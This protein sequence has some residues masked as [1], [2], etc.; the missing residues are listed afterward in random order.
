MANTNKSLRVNANV[1]RDS[2]VNVA[3]NQ[4]YDTFEILSLKLRSEDVYRL[5][6][7]NYGVIV[8]RVVANGNFGVPN[9]KISVFISSDFE[10]DSEILNTLYP[11]ESTASKKDDIRYN[12]LP[13]NKV[14]DCH[15]VVGTFPNKTYLLDN[16]SLIEVFDKYYV[17]T[18]RTNNA[19]DYIIMGVPTGQHTIHMD[20][21][22]SDCGILSQKP[23]D[24][25]YKGYTIEQFEN[26]NQF[27]TDKNLDSLSQIISQ[28]QV[29]NVIPFWGNADNGET[30]GITRADIEISFKFEPTCV[31]IGSLVADNSSNGISKKCVPT[32]Q[33]GAMDELTTGEGTIEMIRKTPGDNIES[34]Q[35]KG[36]ELIDGNGI[37][38][39][40]IPMNLDY[41]MTDEYGN[42]VPTD[43]P[44]KGVPTRARVRFRISMEDNEANVDNYFRAKVLV[45][46]NPLN[47]PTGGHEDYDY[48][49][50]TNTREESFRD[51]FWN[52]VYTVKSYIPRFQKPK[53]NIRTERFSGIK[54][55]N[56][57]GQNN[58][59]PYNN[60]RI[61]LP[62]EF[63][64]LCL[65]V[66]I[67]INVVTFMNRVIYKIVRLLTTISPFGGWDLKIVQSINYI[68]LS[69]GFCEE[70]ENWY[71]AP[72]AN[73]EKEF[74]KNGVPN[75]ADIKI[76]GGND[77]VYLLEECYR[78]LTGS[79]EDYSNSQVQGY[80]TEDG[81]VYI[82]RNQATGGVG[83]TVI[84]NYG[85]EDEYVV[86][87]ETSV[88][89][90]NRDDNDAM[91]LTVNTDYL[92]SCLEMALAQKYK[93]INFD[94]YNDWINGVIYMPR[95]MRVV[96]KKRSFL[97]G[98]IK[99]KPKV[100]GCMDDTRIFNKTRYYLQQCALTY[101]KDE[102][103]VYNNTYNTPNG[104]KETKPRRTP[105]Q[106]CHKKPGK[107]Y[108]PIFGGNK[109]TPTGNGGIVHENET[110]LKEHV[111]YFKP[112]EWGQN[113]RKVLLFANDLVLLGSLNDCSMYGIPQAFRYLKSSTYIMPTNLALTNMEEDGYLYATPDGTIC[114]EKS[115]GS[116]N[117]YENKGLT[118]VDTT[119]EAE[120]KY[121]STTENDQL[122]F[123]N[124]PEGSDIVDIYDDT[125]PL[126]EAAGIAWN[127]TGPGQGEKSTNVNTSLYMPGGHFLGISCFN[128]ETNIKSCINLQRVCEMGSNISQRREEIRE[129]KKVD[130]NGEEYS[131]KYRYFVPTGLISTDDI[132][133]EDFRTMF[134]TMNSKR[135][136]CEDN[137]VDE[138]TGYLFYRFNY[139]RNTGF[140]G[141]LK[142]K[143]EGDKFGAW[144]KKL[145]ITDEY[146][147]VGINVAK[148]VNYD[149]EETGETYTRTWEIANYD[150]FAFRF[151]L[152]D[153]DETEQLKH[154][155]LWVGSDGGTSTSTTTDDRPGRGD[156]G[157]SSNTGSGSSGT[158]S[159]S[160]SGGGRRGLTKGGE[161]GDSNEGN[162][163]NDANG[164]NETG[165]SNDENG[166]EEGSTAG[167]SSGNGSNSGGGTG[168]GGNRRSGAGGNRTSSGMY[169]SNNRN[170]GG[171]TV[172]LPQY[173]N[174]FYFY[175]GLQDGAT[176]LDEFNKQFFSVCETDSIIT[177]KLTLGVKTEFDECEM[178]TTAYI[179]GKDAEEPL[180]ISYTYI[181]EDG[182][183]SGETFE[184]VE[185]KNGYYSLELPD[186]PIGEYTFIA[187]DGT[188]AEE[189]RII[190]LGGNNDV[191]GLVDTQAFIFQVPSDAT[192]QNVS[193]SA[194]TMDC[195][196][197]SVAGLMFNGN[198]ISGVPMVT[199][200]EKDNDG[201][202]VAYY[203][204]ANGTQPENIGTMLNGI[205]T[206]TSIY[207]RIETDED[208]G[209]DGTILVFVWKPDTKYD[210]YVWNNNCDDSKYYFYGT[211]IVGGQEKVNLYLGDND[212][213]ISYDDYLKTL[214][215][216]DEW[217]NDIASDEEGD[218]LLDGI[219]N[220]YLRYY[221]IK[222]TSSGTPFTNNIIGAKDNG[223]IL[224]TRLF[225]QPER[226]DDELEEYRLVNG[227]CY[228]DDK[229]LKGAVS[230]MTYIP[231]WPNPPYTRKLFGE[232]VVNGQNIGSIPLISIRV[233]DIE[234]GTTI[235]MEN[236]VR[237]YHFDLSQDVFPDEELADYLVTGTSLSYAYFIGKT[238]D[239]K[240]YY[241]TVEV[242]NSGRVFKYEG[243][244]LS[245]KTITLYPVFYYPVMDRAFDAKLSDVDWVNPTIVLNGDNNAESSEFNVKYEDEEFAFTIDAVNGI[246]Y[247]NKYGACT[248][249]PYTFDDLVTRED[250]TTDLDLP[251]VTVKYGRIGY[252]KP[253]S[254]TTNCVF[255]LTEGAPSDLP[256]QPKVLK[257]GDSF[258]TDLATYIS[259]RPE[260]DKIVFY[261]DI[262]DEVN[263]YYLVKS[264]IECPIESGATVTYPFDTGSADTVLYLGRFGANSDDLL[265]VFKE[266]NTYV[267]YPG[268]YVIISNQVGTN[269][270]KFDYK[271]NSTTAQKVVKE[272]QSNSTDML[273]GT[274]V[275]DFG[276]TLE[277]TYLLKQSY[278]NED[279]I[280]DMTPYL[281]EILNNIGGDVQRITSFGDELDMNLEEGDYVICLV[282]TEKI[283]FVRVYPK[284]VNLETYDNN[285]SEPY[286]IIIP[287]GTTGIYN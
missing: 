105:K 3:L 181:T 188:G 99:I 25:V 33:M 84:H 250:G 85:D 186:L 190:E 127:Y 279:G 232:M 145:T 74:D 257:V 152:S 226:Y 150:Y 270:F 16:D 158:G 87:D 165:D 143:I 124:S 149:E 22:L 72:G 269:S 284:L 18:T 140:G 161:S 212:F 177:K 282:R 43:D 243:S 14:S 7:A 142:E 247:K 17:Y 242:T 75:M 210:V 253:Y 196:Y 106:K 201:N 115:N 198:E 231:T 57:H 229:R 272:F 154:F 191:D 89:Y 131:I 267:Q 215:P 192:P 240:L 164:G 2:F 61:K 261:N 83:Y 263:E 26:P 128:S 166:G 20:L 194:Q 119:F 90:Q 134:A 21:D 146:S 39:Y 77:N 280:P 54:H 219:D 125:I 234:S 81:D 169:Q 129:I 53:N 5:H 224:D 82:P 254:A 103:G 109:K 237:Y 244:R 156:S 252:L 172:G 223:Y 42:M 101:S 97:W 274:E 38:C 159:G 98:L 79:T 12:L 148:D 286:L 276:I 162:G 19:G 260:N 116:S 227:I 213:K 222:R 29:V 112:C 123:G 66:K 185:V 176:A 217:W 187:V 132:N 230:D 251:E 11:Y 113:N 108:Y 36:T 204:N 63:S 209:E 86:N 32:N 76:N 41:M 277:K 193:K 45:P 262:N 205:S 207:D 285:A 13:D 68:V 58:P 228:E 268:Q 52:N 69:N 78:N 278:F 256:F 9:A 55:C 199:I 258:T 174:S 104:C 163:G 182:E 88:D 197:I 94:F 50:G 195:G 171:R 144:N 56:I 31:F 40:Q 167:G 130:E 59:M 249:G 6:S 23:R 138:K 248:F 218:E 208:T 157:G 259:Y 233:A 47:L 264:T 4:T 155:L 44:T 65:I 27:K 236:G 178:T 265:N 95:W 92:L 221:L 202:A 34:Y 147:N 110:M 255:G 151:G 107:K 283:N 225:G 200:V 120:K 139:L 184:N 245:A 271:V 203:S 180:T 102:N 71:F 183:T 8:G 235:G 30:I 266:P 170:G 100:K 239:G 114:S 141:E 173:E 220:W 80:V 91:C 70:L 49:F 62:L 60:I 275:S 168:K 133:G 238:D 160:N 273:F 64:I 35:V 241:I 28:D 137:F 96:R 153:L 122:E 216:N 93:V 211:Y 246:T 175:F 189:K 48:E 10:N 118:Q 135:L 24:F 214:N 281:E 121:Y 1:G 15:Q 179:S 206:A 51:L 67:F 287:P 126:T 73:T 111:Y 117:F 46:H 136:L 37:W